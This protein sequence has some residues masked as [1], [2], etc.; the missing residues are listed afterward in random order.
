MVK[1]IQIYYDE[2]SKQN[3]DPSFIPYNNEPFTDEYFESSAI[4][5]MVMEEKLHLDCDYFGV[6]SHSVKTKAPLFQQGCG[7][8]LIREIEKHPDADIHLLYY[9]R[10]NPNPLLVD[11]FT[12]I[13]EL[14]FKKLSLSSP[15]NL[16]V[17]FTSYCNYHICRPNI[18]EAYVKSFLYPVIQILQTDAE[19]KPL[20]WKEYPYRLTESMKAWLQ[21]KIGVDY[22][23]YHSFFCERLF[24]VWATIVGKKFKI[25]YL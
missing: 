13:A 14:V 1:I 20:L 2:E 9:D 4:C 10:Y 11:G 7:K 25:N 8:D 22:Y 17:D 21:N 18:Y 19:L 15:S 5:R 3:I 12:E 24:C 23:P 16:I 6:L